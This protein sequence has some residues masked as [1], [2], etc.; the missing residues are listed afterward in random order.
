[1]NVLSLFAGIGGFD[2]GLAR[3]GFHTTEV[4]ETDPYA[5]KVLA[6]RFPDAPNAGDVTKAKY[7]HADIITAG[8]PCQDISYA[9]EGAGLAGSRSGLWREVV[10]AVRM[11]GPRYTIL[12]NV[13]ALLNRGMGTVLG[14]LAEIGHDAEWHCIPASAVG[15]PHRRDRIWIVAYPGSIEHEGSSPKITGPLAAELSRASADAAPMLGTEIE[16]SEPN[17]DHASAG[18]LAGPNCAGL[19]E[20]ELCA[21]DEGGS[22]R[23]PSRQ[24]PALG[25]RWPAEPNVGRV[26]HGVP[27]R[28]DRLRGLGNAVVPQIP[29]WIAHRIKEA[30]GLNA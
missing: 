14:D 29:E 4:A 13:A 16:R 22:R 26:A 9:G 20:R 24:E 17:G 15:A 10:R 27:A 19:S 30:E 11:V 7:R 5:S 6:K 8:F 28:V 2:L 25:G 18:T 3:A 23:P 12:E 21:G 1:M